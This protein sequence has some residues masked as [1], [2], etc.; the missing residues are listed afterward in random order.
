MNADIDIQETY[1]HEHRAQ[2]VTN[3]DVF[4]TVYRGMYSTELWSMTEKE[5]LK[6]MNEDYGETIRPINYNDCA[7]AMLMMWIENIVTDGQYNKIMDK[8]NDK[9]ING[10]I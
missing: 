1:S 6:W 5:F 8:L 7:N 4:K 2:H 3:A 9:H 10:E